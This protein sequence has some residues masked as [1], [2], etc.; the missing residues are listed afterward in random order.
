MTDEELLG[1]RPRHEEV[2]QGLAQPPLRA[3]DRQ[4]EVP[5]AYEQHHGEDRPQH[6]N[7][8]VLQAQRPVQ[9]VP[10]LAHGGAD[11]ARPPAEG[12]QKF[13]EP[14]NGIDV[15]VEPFAE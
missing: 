15:Q 1:A 10:D 2:F 6:G 14:G 8:R 5:A 13:F 7:H 9:P 11:I 4:A 3:K 12:E